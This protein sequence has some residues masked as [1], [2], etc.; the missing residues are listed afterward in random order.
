[1]N[2]ERYFV[3][4]GR[5]QAKQRPRLYRGVAYTPE[6]T[7]LYEAKMRDCYLE[8]HGDLEPLT[9]DVVL[10]VRV[11][12]NKRNHGD[13]DNYLKCCDGVNKV[14]WIDDKQV[15]EIHGF[16]IVDKTEPERMEITITPMEA[17]K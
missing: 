15:K 6:A 12:F 7:R 10:E 1:M 14:A 11:Y 17:K 5:A 4:P 8:A 13:L 2:D 16:L 9:G 3:V